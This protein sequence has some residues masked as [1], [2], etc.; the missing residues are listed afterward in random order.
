MCFPST[1]PR[2]VV[3]ISLFPIPLPKPRPPPCPSLCP[4]RRSAARAVGARR[5]G[6]RRV[7]L[8]SSRAAESPSALI[9]QHRA[10]AR[11]STSARARASLRGVGVCARRRDR[12]S[13]ALRAALSR[14]CR[15]S[16]PLRRSSASVL[17]GSSEA[18]PEL[19]LQGEGVN[20]LEACR[21]AA[22][23]A[24]AS[25]CA[26]CISH[27]WVPPPRNAATA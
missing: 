3:C 1:A 17:E 2:Y 7:L 18:Q 12:P 22:R 27:R 26:A 13:R 15:V 21:R 16:L 9:V 24:T 6:P 8:T 19:R 10:A 14:R 5:P 20:G 23:E 4:L 25:R 11:V